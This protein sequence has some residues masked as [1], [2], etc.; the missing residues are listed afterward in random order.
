[1]ICKDEE[2]TDEREQ[3]IVNKSLIKADREDKKI[4]IKVKGNETTRRG[5]L[6][7]IRSHFEIIHQSLPGL[8]PEITE[9]ISLP[10][11]PK[12][13]IDYEY[14]L[15]LEQDGVETFRPKGYRQDVNVTNLLN[16][17]ESESERYQRQLKLSPNGININVT[18]TQSNSMENSNTN[19]ANS[20]SGDNMGK[21]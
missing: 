7:V 17:F 12:V 21:S 14:L 3:L 6:S 1:M 15:E 18:Q 5:F 13:I 9:H 16:G 4:F 10:E 8:N 19:Q 2:I 20:G 11:D